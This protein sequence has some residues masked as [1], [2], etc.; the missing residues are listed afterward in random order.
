MKRTATATNHNAATTTTERIDRDVKEGEE[1]EQDEGTRLGAL[2]PDALDAA[3]V[4]ADANGG[5]NLD[6]DKNNIHQI[7]RPKKLR[8][9]EDFNKVHCFE[10]KERR[11]KM[12]FYMNQLRELVPVPPEAAET[13]PLR[14][15]GK[16]DMRRTAGPGPTG[17][18]RLR[19][20]NNVLADTVH[21]IHQLHSEIDMLKTMHTG[22]SREIELPSESDPIK[23]PKVE[24]EED[25]DDEE[26][27]EQEGEDYSD[28]APTVAPVSETRRAESETTKKVE[29]GS[30][31]MQPRLHGKESEPLLNV[32]VKEEE[33]IVYISVDGP[34]PDDVMYPAI[35]RTLKSTLDSNMFV[36]KGI[37]RVD[38]NGAMR[39]DENGAEVRKYGLLNAHEPGVANG[40]EYEKRG[41]FLI[42]IKFSESR[43]LSMETFKVRF[44]GFPGQSRRHTHT[45]THTVFRS[46]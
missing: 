14:E 3:K 18:G 21:Y 11:D 6:E 40:T 41:S 30:N 15:D 24:V 23:T 17:S 2:Q 34:S 16:P 46:L 26:E 44:T 9:G 19:T 22:H 42:E 20:K 43:S 37:Q 39:N 8:K 1:E 28:P 12:N 13:V 36:V 29:G 38:S 4:E 27:E 7:H 5:L 35:L 10:E 32:N 25:E 45:H 31:M 33:D